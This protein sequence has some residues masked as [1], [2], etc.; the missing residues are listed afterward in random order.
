MRKALSTLIAALFLSAI[1]MIAL[2]T[3]SA[4]DAGKNKAGVTFNKDVAPIF[5]KD[6]V[7]CHRPGE[8]APMSL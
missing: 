2:P 4:S 3:A 7:Q 5:Y 8:I 1:C 6:C